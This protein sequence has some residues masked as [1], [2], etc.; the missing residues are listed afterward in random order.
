[1]KV[2]SKNKS[3]K[4]APNEDDDIATDVVAEATVAAP[5][6]VAAQA[7]VPPPVTEAAPVN[8]AAP[9]NRAPKVVAPVAGAKPV[10]VYVPKADPAWVT[11]SITRLVDPPPQIGKFNLAKELKKTKLV[12][13]MIVRVPLHVAQHMK[14]ANMCIISNIE[15]ADRKSVV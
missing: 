12:P 3:S 6:P 7:P 5:A 1:M 4:V 11:I 2:E 9:F 13:G 14:D 8:A 10:V 15:T